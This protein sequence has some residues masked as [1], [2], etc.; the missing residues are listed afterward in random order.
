MPAMTTLFRPVGLDELALIWDSGMREF[1]PRLPHQP[2]FYPVAKMEYATQIARDWNTKDSSFA[3]YVT[4]F[5]VSDAY[6]AKFEPHTVGSATHVEFWIPAEQ[7]HEFNASIEGRISLE[8]A[9]FGSGFKG[10]VPDSFGLKGK[11]AVEQFVAMA[12]RWDYSRVDFVCE[13]STNRKAVYLNFL[14]WADFDFSAQD[15]DAQQRNSIIAHIR[16]AWDFNH[17]EIPLPA[18]R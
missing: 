7:I 17:I 14:F 6:L 2:I 15:V 3:G 13:A 18:C 11:D 1:P 12:K 9:F 16:E 5:S 8:S 10:F 4:K